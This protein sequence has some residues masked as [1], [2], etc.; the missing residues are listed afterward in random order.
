MVIV[1]LMM[2]NNLAFAIADII[3]Q[4]QAELLNN[5]A[6]LNAAAKNTRHMVDLKN[7]WKKYS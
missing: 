2:K 7:E 1:I 3:Y 4:P 6:S 5:N